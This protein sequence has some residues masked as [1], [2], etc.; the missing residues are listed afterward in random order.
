MQWIM[1][2]LNP[3]KV[4]ILCDGARV[5]AASFTGLE[6]SNDAAFKILLLRPGANSICSK[7][8]REKK[9]SSNHI[10]V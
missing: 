9:V 3:M 10:S 2:E 8:P 4:E 6:V 5:T 1:A 7:I